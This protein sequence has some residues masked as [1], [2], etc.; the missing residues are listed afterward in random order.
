M[1]DTRIPGPPPPPSAGV[2]PQPPLPAYGAP[3]PPSRPGRAAPR[4]VALLT[5][6]VGV[7]VLIG[8]VWSSS[9]PTFAAGLTRSEDRSVAVAGVETLR[10]DAAATRLTIGFADV[11]EATLEVERSAG[12][13]TLER[14]GST[15]RV[16]SPRRPFLGWLAGGNNGTATLTLPR[17]LEGVDARVSVGAGSVTVGGDFGAVEVDLGAGEATVT[18]TARELA[19]DVG[20]GRA[21]VDLD[22]VSTA[23]LGVSAGQMIARLEGTAPSDVRVRVSA[24]SLE[25]TLPDEVYHVVSDVAAGG[26]DNRL[27]T[28]ADSPRRVD[29]NVAAGNV[30]VTAD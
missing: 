4:V 15:L 8:A 7:V 30:R 17:S 21:I 18:G 12:S 2:P 3:T 10:V 11:R 25:L 16:E 27:R 23:V 14:D 24:G 5:V 6:V 26:F 20:A 29:V 13:W 9:L 28:S 19:A 22:G 1:S